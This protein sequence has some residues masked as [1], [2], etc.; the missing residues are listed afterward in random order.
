MKPIDFGALITLAIA[1]VTGIA[2]AIAKL[3]KASDAV[4]VIISSISKNGLVT[5]DEIDAAVESILSGGRIPRV[6]ADC[7]GDIVADVIMRLPSYLGQPKKD[8]VSIVAGVFSKQTRL[9]IKQALS[10][11]PDRVL[12]MGWSIREVVSR[13]LEKTDVLELK[14]SENA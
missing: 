12:V 3:R 10:T 9:K 2:T 5:H 8:R 13:I 1:V 6:F 7:I 4:G 11:L 14:E